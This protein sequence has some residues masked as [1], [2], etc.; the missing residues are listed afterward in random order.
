MLKLIPGGVALLTVGCAPLTF[1][2][3]PAGCQQR[4][5]TCMNSCRYSSGKPVEQPLNAGGGQCCAVQI[6]AAS[7]TSRCNDDAKACVP[8]SAE[9]VEGRA[10]AQ[11]EIHSVW[12]R[13]SPRS[14]ERATLAGAA[15]ACSAGEAFCQQAVSRM[16]ECFGDVRQESF[17]NDSMASIVLGMT[18][19]EYGQLTGMC[20]AS[21]D[22]DTAPRTLECVRHAIRDWNQTLKPS[23]D[24]EPVRLSWI[25]P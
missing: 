1:G 20:L 12:P 3:L 21:G 18:T 15:S 6:E 7:C 25:V 14:V 22:A 8:P 16:H 10:P 24:E 5:D 9:R 23:L 17:P 2:T 13:C 4:Y 11:F 19:D